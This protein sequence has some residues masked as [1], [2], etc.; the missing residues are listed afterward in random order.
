MEFPKDIQCNKVYKWTD[1]IKF[2]MDCCF[3]NALL[4]LYL[5]PRNK[6]QG[7]ILVEQRILELEFVWRI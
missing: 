4:L 1:I 7:E 3:L 5:V 6:L 2:K